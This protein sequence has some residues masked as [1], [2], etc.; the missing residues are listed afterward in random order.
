MR[1]FIKNQFK[2]GI[3]PYMTVIIMNNINQLR[4]LAS[5]PIYI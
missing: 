3:E 2:D 4:I 1:L 5:T